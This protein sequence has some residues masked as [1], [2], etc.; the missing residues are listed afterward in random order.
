MNKTHQQ[1]K[2]VSLFGAAP[3]SGN[4]GVTALSEATLVA[5]ANRGVQEVAQFGFSRG[6]RRILSTESGTLSV[7]RVV[8]RPTRKIY[9]IDSLFAFKLAARSN[10]QLHGPA[11]A[12]L[13]SDAVLDISAGDSLS[14]IYGMRRF[15]EVVTPKQLAISTGIPLVLLPQTIGPF[16]SEEA[17]LLAKKVLVGA[18]QVWARDAKSYCDLQE[19][20]G[21]EFDDQKHFQG[22]DMAFLLQPREPARM[23]D[24]LYRW[25]R[26]SQTGESEI[27]GINVSGLIY[28]TPQASSSQFGLKA[29]YRAAVVQAITKLLSVS[30]RVKIVLVPHVHAPAGTRESDHDASVHLLEHFPEHHRSRVAILPPTFH[31]AELKWIISHSSFFFG[32]RMHSTIAGLGSGI[33]TACL[34]YSMKTRGVFESC[35]MA[36]HAIELRT[37]STSD[38]IHQLMRAWRNRKAIRSQLSHWIP[39]VIKKANQQMDEIVACS[40]TRN[41][42]APGLGL[43]SEIRTSRQNDGKANA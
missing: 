5:L 14:D 11:K 19:L 7:R 43:S 17:K 20:L 3:D 27:V 42:L 24:Q 25:I 26:E 8:A 13:N 4:Q 16:Q 30:E 40:P 31:A 23:P 18:K 22:V 29:D 2:R 15:Q 37:C 9:R 10:I 32:T 36:D 21:D 6:Q 33:P 41:T 38:A 12:F 35:G 28:N 39:Q 34:S 1:L